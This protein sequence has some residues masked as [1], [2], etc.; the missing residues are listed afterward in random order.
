M[1]EFA[2]VRRY[3]MASLDFMSDVALAPAM[4]AGES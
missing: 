4:L 1:S 2:L 3:K